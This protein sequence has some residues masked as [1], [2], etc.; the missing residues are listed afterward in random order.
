MLAFFLHLLGFWP[1]FAQKF[2]KQTSN[3][4]KHE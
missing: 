2:S 1:N 3:T 4:D